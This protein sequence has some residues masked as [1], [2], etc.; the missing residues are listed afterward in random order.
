[1][2]PVEKPCPCPGEVAC[3]FQDDRLDILLR[4]I[5][6]KDIFFEDKAE[7]Q[8]AAVGKGNGKFPLTALQFGFNRL[9]IFPETELKTP[10]RH[11]VRGAVKVFTVK[12]LP[13]STVASVE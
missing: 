4:V 13:K 10:H 7:F 12:E 2:S 3:R 5:K 11:T 8:S 6:V 9:H 1:M